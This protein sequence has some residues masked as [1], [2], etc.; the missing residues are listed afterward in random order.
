MRGGDRRGSEVILRDHRGLRV[1]HL[2]VGQDLVVL[3]ELGGVDHLLVL[4]G[5]LEGKFLIFW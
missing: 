5:L 3:N 4:R 2:Q 1:G